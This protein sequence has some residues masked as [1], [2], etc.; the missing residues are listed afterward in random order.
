MC[1]SIDEAWESLLSTKVKMTPLKM[2]L[3]S[4]SFTSLEDRMEVFFGGPLCYRDMGLVLI[5]WSK[6]FSSSYAFINIQLL[7]VLLVGFLPHICCPKVLEVVSDVLGVF[8][9]VSK[10]SLS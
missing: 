6:K 4:F 3:F 2:S 1:L 9:Q 5:P 8:Q 10:E 7:W